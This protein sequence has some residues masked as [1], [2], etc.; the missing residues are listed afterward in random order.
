MHIEL[1]EEITRV[2]RRMS[3][4]GL[5]PTTSGNV[6]ARTPEGD[7]LIT[8]SGLPYEDL[9]PEDMVLVDIEGKVLEGSLQ[10]CS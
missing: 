4:S 6:S 3:D 10:R 5:V 1:R 9:E 8:P 7:V 2:S